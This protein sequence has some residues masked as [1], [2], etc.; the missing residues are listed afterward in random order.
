VAD[1]DE[2]DFEQLGTEF[3]DAVRS[4]INADD[5]SITTIQAFAVMFL[6]D[7]ARANGLRA[8]SYLR[9][10]SSSLS[11]VDYHQNEGFAEVWKTT[12]R[13]VRNLNV[14]VRGKPFLLFPLMNSVNGRR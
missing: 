6:V 9:V 12:V 1:G 14:S 10:A 2:V 11:S 13:G 7:C 5:K 3:S 8:S 4:D